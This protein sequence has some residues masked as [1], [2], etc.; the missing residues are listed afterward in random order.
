LFSSYGCPLDEIWRKE[1]KGLELTIAAGYHR[2]S[3]S[4]HL[5]EDAEIPCRIVD[6]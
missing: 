4:L 3:A 2:I 6:F 1:P 5:D